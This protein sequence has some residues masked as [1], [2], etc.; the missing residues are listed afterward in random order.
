MQLQWSWSYGVRDANKRAQLRAEIDAIVAN[1]YGL[2]E[3]D[4]AYVL[5]SFPLLDRDQPPLPGEERSFVTR[6]LALLA[7]F[8]LRSKTPPVD[9][10]AFFNEAGVDIRYRTGPII[11][12]NERVR[13]AT[14]ELGAV[15]YQPSS[16]DRDGNSETDEILDQEELD[17]NDDEE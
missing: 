14:Q 13:I 9:V 5:N 6:D 7:L 8:L 15:A 2:S 12:L 17:F 1:L 4:F 3:H 16:H 11:D 10:I